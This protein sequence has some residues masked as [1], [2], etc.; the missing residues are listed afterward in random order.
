MRDVALASVLFV[1]VS[2]GRDF[3]MAI[4]QRLRRERLHF[5]PS[6]F[7]RSH[8][9]RSLR[10]TSTLGR[11]PHRAREKDRPPDISAPLH[12][13][14]DQRSIIALKNVVEKCAVP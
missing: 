10:T 11:R 3:G 6:R 8:L 5:M 13:I 12:N 4:A 2:P 1:P 7:V 9:I 14:L